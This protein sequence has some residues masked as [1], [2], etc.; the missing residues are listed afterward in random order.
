MTSSELFDWDDGRRLASPHEK[1][2]ELTPYP[3]TPYPAKPY[4]TNKMA[5]ISRCGNWNFYFPSLGLSLLS[6]RAQFLEKSL[7]RL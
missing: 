2:I 6:Q 7:T 3:A 5:V 4:P 1:G